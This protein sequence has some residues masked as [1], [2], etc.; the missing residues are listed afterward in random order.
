MGAQKLH[1]IDPKEAKHLGSI[2]AAARTRIATRDPAFAMF[3]IKLS[4]DPMSKG[5]TADPNET[6]R[7]AIIPWLVKMFHEC[8]HHT[9]AEIDFV[10]PTSIANRRPTKS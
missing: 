10:N 9:V 6:A 7:I 8:V 1:S 2:E 3:A 4:A 5:S